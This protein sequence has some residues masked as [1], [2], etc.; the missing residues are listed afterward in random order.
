MERPQ[1]AMLGTL[2]VQL[3]FQEINEN[4]IGIRNSVIFS[5]EGSHLAALQQ[6]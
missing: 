3:K 5:N 6:A 1:S 2:N 4:L